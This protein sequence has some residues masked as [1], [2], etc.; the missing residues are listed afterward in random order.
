VDNEHYLRESLRDANMIDDVECDLMCVND[1]CLVLSEAMHPRLGNNSPAQS[2]SSDIIRLIHS[3]LLIIERYGHPLSDKIDKFINFYNHNQIII[4]DI[5]EFKQLLTRYGE[6][7]DPDF[8]TFWDKIY[9]KTIYYVCGLNI[10]M[11]SLFWLDMS[12]FRVTSQILKRIEIFK[13]SLMMNPD[14]PIKNSLFIEQS[15]IR[16]L[17]YLRPSAWMIIEVLTASLHKHYSNIQIGEDPL[18]KPIKTAL[19]EAEFD[20]GT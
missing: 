1:A 16:H 13:R 19:K 7:E 10:A 5:T 6:S 3:Y 11:C 20:W 18:E 8:N 14:F 9:D 15:I 2:L 17:M 4:I 12:G